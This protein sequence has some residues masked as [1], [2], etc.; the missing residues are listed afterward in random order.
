[1]TNEARTGASQEEEEALAAVTFMMRELSFEYHDKNYDD[2]FQIVTP[3]FP[4]SLFWSSV[5]F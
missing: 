5:H 2:V 4:E 1:L 3:N